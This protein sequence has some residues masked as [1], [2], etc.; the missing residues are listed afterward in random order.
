MVCGL[1]VRVAY[2]SI[3]RDVTNKKEEEVVIPEESTVNDLI[4]TLMKTYG[5]KLKPF[6]D[7]DSEMGQGIILTLNGELLSSSDLGRKIPDNAEFLVGLPP[8]GG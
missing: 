6:L 3:L 8:F 5:D 4:S 2:L 1:K 7:P